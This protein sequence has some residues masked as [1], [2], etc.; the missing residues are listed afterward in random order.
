MA[1]QKIQKD[2]DDAIRRAAVE[3]DQLIKERD[4]ALAAAV[5]VGVETLVAPTDREKAR[6]PTRIR[7]PRSWTRS[8]MQ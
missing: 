8:W 6:G 2:K 1:V 4:D 5:N 3:R 7:R